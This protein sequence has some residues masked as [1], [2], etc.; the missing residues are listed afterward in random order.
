MK[1]AGAHSNLIGKLCK[2]SEFG[3]VLEKEY[4][5]LFG[6]GNEQNAELLQYYC[7]CGGPHEV[8]LMFID[9]PPHQHYSLTFYCVKEVG[10]NASGDWHWFT[11]DQLILCN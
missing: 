6:I 3:V 2:L 9:E 7:F 1:I 4:R 10:K 8:C 11:L 5:E